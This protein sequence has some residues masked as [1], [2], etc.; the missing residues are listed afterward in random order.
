MGFKASFIVIEKAAG[1]HDDREILK[2]LG[3]ES[4]QYDSETTFETCINPSDDGVYLGYFNDALIVCH[5]DIPLRA[6]FGGNQLSK[7]E[8]NLTLLFP[9]REILA[10]VCHS[11]V[12]LQAYALLKDG[13]KVRQ[14][15]CSSDIPVEEFGEMLAEEKPIYAQATLD[16]S[17]KRIWKNYEN[18]GSD[19]YEDQL[20]EEFTFG[21][22]KRLLGVQIS[23]GED[24]VLFFETPFK[25][26]AKPAK[27]IDPF[28]EAEKKLAETPPTFSMSLSK[29]ML[30][31]VAGLVLLIVALRY[32]CN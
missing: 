23:T 18:S 5:A 7:I 29:F 17:G 12:N 13:V 19:Y 6:F 25:R 26:Y 15:S 22:A 21:V 4:Y 31:V 2:S 24:D 14:K 32:V 11:V 16:E 20:M 1:L 28:A 10:A 8:K 27:P 30:Y 3:F 9:N